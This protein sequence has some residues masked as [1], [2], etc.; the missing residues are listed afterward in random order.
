[1]KRRRPQPVAYP[2]GHFTALMRRHDW[3][4]RFRP[5][6]QADSDP[7]RS[8]RS[9]ATRDAIL[10]RGGWGGRIAGIS[11]ASDQRPDIDRAKLLAHRRGGA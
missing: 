7:D 3:P 2:A 9:S 11:V 8:A 5:Q 1:M 10:A 6:Y 4:P